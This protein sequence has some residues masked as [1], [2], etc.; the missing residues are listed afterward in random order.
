MDNE[1]LFTDKD[2]QG[3]LIQVCRDSLLVCGDEEHLPK[4][5]AKVLCSL[6]EDPE[7]YLLSD[8]KQPEKQEPS[9]ILQLIN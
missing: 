6:L 4:K 8:I 3:Y 5:K 7:T 2:E 1:L 9:S